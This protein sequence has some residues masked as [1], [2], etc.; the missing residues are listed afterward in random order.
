MIMENLYEE[1]LTYNQISF[2][3]SRG[4]SHMTGNEIHPY[5]EILYYM[6]GDASFLS[7]KYQENLS[8][9]TLLLIPKA[10]YHQFYIRNQN[11]YTR[12][13]LTFPDIEGTEG[14]LSSTMNEIKIIRNLN[15][16]LSGT[17]QR[18][19]QVIKNTN[20]AQERSVFLYGAFLMLLAEL[21][22]ENVKITSPRLREGDPLIQECIRYI[23][24]NFTKSI[25]VASIAKKIGVSESALAHSFKKDLGIS[26]YKYI[27]EKRLVYAHKLISENEKPTKIYLDCG[28][29]DYP[30]FYKAYLKMFGYP[31]SGR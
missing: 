23:D 3:Y 7:E 9:N 26:L 29:N 11:R 28:Y 25:T 6:D 17:L 14:L 2:R 15:S 18:M 24:E 10:S 1:K 13:A 12:L 8:A 21:N 22:M 20:A 19:C 4:K 30:T 5:H 27:V 16:H 31:P